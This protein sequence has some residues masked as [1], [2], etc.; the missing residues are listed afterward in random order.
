MNT[1]TK[2]PI[3]VLVLIHTA[4]LDVLLLQRIGSAGL[5]QSVTG[6]R[7]GHEN[8]SDTALREVAEETGIHAAP[9]ALIDWHITNRFEILPHWRG[10]YGAGITYNTE[11]LFS[12]CLPERLPVRLAADEHVAACWLPWQDAAARVFSWTNRDAIRLLARRFSPAEEL[13][14]SSS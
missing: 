13:P 6:S 9:D 3:S 8:L 11:H 7:E 1:T 5:W 4:S 10:R 2:Q 14:R 12:L